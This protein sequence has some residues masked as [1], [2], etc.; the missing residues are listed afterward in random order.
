MNDEITAIKNAII[1]TVPV[2][3]LFLFGSYANGTQNGHSDYDFYIII[4][5]DSMRPIDAIGDAQLAMRG[6]KIKPVDILAGTV[7]IFNRRSKL[8]TIERKIANEGILLYER[9]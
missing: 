9:E 8:M 5:N 4:P 7:E 6:M 1:K 3:K 2:E